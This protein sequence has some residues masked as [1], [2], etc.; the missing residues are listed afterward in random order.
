MTAR[1]IPVRLCVFTGPFCLDFIHRL[2]KNPRHRG[3]FVPAWLRNSGRLGLAGAG[4]AR[5]IRAA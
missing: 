2:F 5:S 3:K 4:Y 1:I